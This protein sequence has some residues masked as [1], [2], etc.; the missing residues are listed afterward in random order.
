MFSK[1]DFIPSQDTGQIRATTEAS[2]RTSFEKMQR[3]QMTAAAI[4]QKDPNVQMVMSFVYGGGSRSGSVAGIKASLK[5]KDKRQHKCWI[6]R[7]S[8]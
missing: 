7:N 6:G 1:T 3:Y 2:D 8:Q 5:L 4:A